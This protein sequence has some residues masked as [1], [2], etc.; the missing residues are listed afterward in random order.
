MK[1]E[2]Y[3]LSFFCEKN[4]F[5]SVYF[6]S[7]FRPS[8]VHL[9][10]FLKALIL[11][12]PSIFVHIVPVLDLKK[13][14][15]YSILKII[16]FHKKHYLLSCFSISAKKIWTIRTNMD[17]PLKILTFRKQQTWTVYGRNTDSSWTVFLSL[18]IPFIK[19]Y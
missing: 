16:P 3:Y 8:S 12:H 17:E 4:N 1:R 7:I 9:L 6:P 2:E 13:E 10:H 18:F 19:N 11:L 5:S 14:M 15:L